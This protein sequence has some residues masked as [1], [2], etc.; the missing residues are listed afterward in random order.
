MLPRLLLALAS[1]ALGVALLEGFL[2]VRPPEPDGFGQTR[3]AKRWHA[4]HWKPINSGG[5]RDVE[6]PDSV[7]RST[8][9]LVVLGDSFAAGAGVEDVEERFAGVLAD[10]LGEGWSVVVLARR[11]WSTREQADALA[12]FSPAPHEVVLA[13]YLNDIEGAAARHGRTFEVD[14]SVHPSSLAPLVERSA[15]ANLLYWRLR[16]SRIWRTGRGYADF[17]YEAFADEAI[18]RSHRRELERLLAE[19]RRRGA[20]PVVVLF[21]HLFDLEGSR[22]PIARLERFFRRTG[23]PVVDIGSLIREGDWSRG[24]LFAGPL[25]PHPS[26]ALHRAVAEALRPH[27]GLGS[28]GGPAPGARQPPSAHSGPNGE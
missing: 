17:V 6:H 4:R 1:V 26:P 25:D 24:E 2:R 22:E 19:V 9:R 14:L 7:L 8:R 12:R 3:A 13:Y 16:R 5:F 23:V 28:A 18:W 20:L 15:L 10:D 27:V 21:P 11:G